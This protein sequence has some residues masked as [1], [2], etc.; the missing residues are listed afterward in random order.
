MAGK[1]N[2]VIAALEDASALQEKIRM[3]ARWLATQLS[4][5]DLLAAED[6][7]ID[8]IRATEAAQAALKELRKLEHERPKAERRR[9]E[10]E[11]E[12]LAQSL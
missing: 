7:L 5:K 11:A 8:I 12:I 6:W 9:I 4:G 1:E 3:R 2:P 10:D